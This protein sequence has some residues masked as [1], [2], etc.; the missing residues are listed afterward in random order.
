MP[1]P[2]T[3][4]GGEQRDSQTKANL[5]KI[6]SPYDLNSDIITKSINLLNNLTGYDY[7]S[8]SIINIV[9]RLI[10]AQNSQ[11][12]QVGATRL[13]VEFGRRAVTNVLDGFIPTPNDLVPNF[14]Q[15]FKGGFR[16]YDTQITDPSKNPN[17]AFTDKVLEGTIG[18]R[19]NEN[20]LLRLQN[21]SNISDY[22]YSSNIHFY[23]SGKLDQEKLI[24][25]GKLNTFTPYSSNISVETDLQS[26]IFQNT[27]NPD[28][29]KLESSS[30]RGL[31]ESISFKDTRYITHSYF[32]LNPIPEGDLIKN[33]IQ[34]RKELEG[35]QGFGSL[36]NSPIDEKKDI[37]LRKNLDLDYKNNIE[38]ELIYDK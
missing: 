29:L 10:D 7:R 14:K 6:D 11:L 16:K 22:T 2:I 23:H 37:K 34:E 13:L 12:L 18:Y 32:T 3:T 5:Y 9:E 38:R 1:T 4:F 36:A 26:K 17:R 33:Y 25:L 31:T 24:Q 35:R 28:W 30:E 15:F 19:S 8:N 21:Q 20:Y 27:Y